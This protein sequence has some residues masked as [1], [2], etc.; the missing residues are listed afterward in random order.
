MMKIET[1]FSFDPLDNVILS[2]HKGKN[3]DKN[4]ESKTERRKQRQ[5][6]G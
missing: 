2:R 4:G 1:K 3:E 5:F 6:N